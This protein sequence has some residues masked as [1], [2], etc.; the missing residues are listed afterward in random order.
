MARRS[1]SKLYCV[2]SAPER[3]VRLFPDAV[4]YMAP[5]DTV[6]VPL[7]HQCAV[8]GV[9]LFST[10]MYFMSIVIV[11][12][13]VHR[14]ELSPF[15]IGLVLGCR[16]VLPLFLSIHAG[17]L[18]DRIGARRVLLVFAVL[19]MTVPLLF[20]L[21][22]FVWAVVVLQLLSGM[23]DSMGWL[24]AQTLVGQL[25]KGS[26]H[27]AGRL[28]FIIRFGHLAGPP[29]VGAAWDNWGPWGAFPVI[30]AW[31]IGFFASA[32]LLP[33]AAPHPVRETGPATPRPRFRARDVLPNPADYIDA[34]RLLAAP[35]VAITV[36]IGMMTH[37][38]NSVQATF[39]VVWLQQIGIP[40]TLIGV[41]VS[42]SAIA[43]GLGSL[44]AARLTR[45][46]RP[47]W[48]LLS[49]IWIAILLIAIT[50]ALGSYVALMIVLSLRSAANGIHQPL[51][52]TLTLRAVG[53]A[54]HGKGIGLRATANRVAAISAPV[55]M[56]AMAE[57]I[58]IAASF[59]V[60]GAVASVIMAL[61]AWKLVKHPEVHDN[62][63]E[64]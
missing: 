51:V 9:G 58:G 53:P 28:G 2:S 45:Y 49:V 21:A 30:S 14:L 31:A 29:M 55:L 27:Y 40:G 52:I 47:Y 23:A 48:L 17:A 22:P 5:P 6:P 11:P 16:S 4:D 39:Y 12:L 43:A 18:M 41:L 50:P 46:I 42:V 35:A 3:P 38:G 34:F 7:R 54:S 1:H 24:G 56:G 32:L 19:G 60:I 59:Y 8:Y 10:S 44:V 25:F 33:T 26:T 61:L 63:P 36:L 20:P 37:V 13:W 62:A 64:F 15:M 57:W